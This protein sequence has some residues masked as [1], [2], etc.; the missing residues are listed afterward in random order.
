MTSAHHRVVAKG[1]E[2][3]DVDERDVDDRGVSRDGRHVHPG[4][5]VGHVDLEHIRANVLAAFLEGV[6]KA[7][8]HRPQAEEAESALCVGRHRVPRRNGGDRVARGSE[9]RHVHRHVPGRLPGKLD[10]LNLRCVTR[11]PGLDHLDRRHAD[12]QREVERCDTARARHQPAVEVVL[13]SG[14]EARAV[15]S[16]GAAIKQQLDAEHPPR[17]R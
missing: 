6:R 1:V 14:H 16:I 11:I 10:R 12:R 2:R 4:L 3:I 17:R 7:L 13:A 5:Q 9:Q 15:T 8:H